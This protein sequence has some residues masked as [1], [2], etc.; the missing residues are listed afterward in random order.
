MKSGVE[1]AS[2][3]E[4]LVG[5]HLPQLPVVKNEDTVYALN[6]RQPVSDHQGGAALHNLVRRFLDLGFDFRHPR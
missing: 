5:P 2:V 1:P 4:L 3:Q 6:G